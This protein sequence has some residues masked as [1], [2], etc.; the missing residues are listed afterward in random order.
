MADLDGEI[1]T[2]EEVPAHLKSVNAR[3]TDGRVC[4]F[5]LDRQITASIQNNQKQVER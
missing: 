3:F 4:R 2:F 5:E 1:L